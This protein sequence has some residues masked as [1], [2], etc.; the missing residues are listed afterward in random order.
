[1]NIDNILLAHGIHA[2]VITDGSVD[3]AQIADGAIT[4][5]KIADGTITN[6]DLATDVKIGSLASLETAAKN[7]VVSA[8]NELQLKSNTTNADLADLNIMY[9]MGGI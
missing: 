4:S 5:N 7:N 6:N 1:M 2:T 8:V 9:W 3:T